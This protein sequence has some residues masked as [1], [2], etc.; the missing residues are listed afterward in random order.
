MLGM[1]REDAISHGGLALVQLL[2]TEDGRGA[3]R[4]HAK[5]EHPVWS[6]R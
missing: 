5:G 3:V 6:G 4:A 1:S 2:A